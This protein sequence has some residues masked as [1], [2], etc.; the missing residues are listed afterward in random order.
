[1]RLNIISRMEKLRFYLNSESHLRSTRKGY[2]GKREL[3]KYFD[4]KGV[5]EEYIE[6]YNLDRV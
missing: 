4:E 5:K 2:E 3:D 1:M 6:K